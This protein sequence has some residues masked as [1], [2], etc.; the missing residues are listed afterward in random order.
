M[1]L[2]EQHID[3]LYHFTRKQ[4]VEWYDLQT[5]LVD[6]L[7]NDIE[8][9]WQ[10]SPNL[11]FFEARNRA[12][13][14]FGVFGFMEIVEKRQKAMNKRY[15][16]LLFGYLKVWFR[17]PQLIITVLASLSLY[18]ILLL[19]NAGI[20][21]SVLAITYAAWSLVSA[22]HYKR[23][24]NRQKKQ[25]QKRWLLEQIIYVNAFSGFLIFSQGLVQVFNFIDINKL[26]NIGALMFTI[27]IILSFLYLYC[28]TIVIP[29]NADKHLKETYP[30]FV[31]H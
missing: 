17:L 12:F 24:L 31:L 7:A 16:K 25:K 28:T 23:K 13:K 19:D 3:E 20:V 30:D 18:K 11:S 6:H 5:E 26:S 29:K 27:G 22:I 8:A 10:E 4:Y 21:I 9:I 14:K 1:K 2:T 15:F